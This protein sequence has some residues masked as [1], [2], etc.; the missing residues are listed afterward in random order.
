MKT[1][2]KIAAVVFILLLALPFMLQLRVISPAEGEIEL[3]YLPLEGYGAGG[4]VGVY[5]L[6]ELRTVY[7]EENAALE[8]AGLWQG[9]EVIITDLPAY[10][11]R[12]K[13]KELGGTGIYV[14]CTVTTKRTVKDAA[15]GA[16]LGGG[17][18][19]S[20]SLGYDDGDLNSEE[21]SHILWETLTEKFYGSGFD[22][23]PVS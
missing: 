14:E 12:Y 3:L 23:V 2:L 6:E 7:G 5:L 20:A 19:I 15:S 18:R 22:A 16:E 11:L 10:E 4:S 13:G 21:P 9:K 8:T 1:F 17:I